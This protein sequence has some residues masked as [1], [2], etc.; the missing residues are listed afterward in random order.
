MYGGGI[1][2]LKGNAVVGQSGGPT[3]AINATLSGVIR[4]TLEKRDIINT[5]YGMRNGIE[6]LLR[7]DLVDLTEMFGNAPE[8]LTTLEHTPA[9]ALGS[10][11][12]KLPAVRDDRDFYERVIGI[13]KKYDIRYF[14][15]I[16]GNDSMDTV[17]K[18][19]EYTRGC[20]YEMRI[21]GVPKT[22]DNDL[23]VTD[24]TPGFGSAAKYISTVT[25]EIIRDCA[26]YT[27]PAVTIVEIMGRD[28]GWLTAASAVG[29]LT[30]K[31]APDYV[32][33]PEV[34]FDNDAFFLDVEHALGR[35][36][37][38]VIAVSEG[39]RYSNGHYVGAAAQ[40]GATDV[41]GHAYLAGTGKAL[42][43]LVKKKFGCKVRSVE[44][45]L[46][47]RCASHIASRTDIEESVMI[48]RA[49]TDAAAAG[50]SC[51]MMTFKRAEGDEYSV[52]AEHHNVS[53]IANKTKHV[54]REFINS[55]GNGVTEECCRYILPLIVGESYPEYKDGM[56]EFLT[57]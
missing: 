43:R 5:L 33:L 56:P 46:P 34:D 17:A 31:G 15:Y 6:G 41:F 20:G 42:E 28:A 29:S 35:H 7:S 57:I 19:S 23:V 27:V 52:T 37:N 39:I 32:Y 21:I 44:L 3:A 38:V 30:G 9:A 1:S 48:G 36:P 18:L 45:N 10:C 2:M 24:H 14:F 54:P 49:A 53:E 12:K 25:Q 16:G 26:V 55:E 8:K 47:Q 13:F 50:M 51:Q 22:I 4:G 40:S 11:R